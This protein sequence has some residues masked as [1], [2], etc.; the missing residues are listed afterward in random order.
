MAHR[1]VMASFAGPVVPP[2]MLARLEAG[3]GSVALF[4]SNVQSPSQVRSLTDAL[5]QA[6]SG[7]LVATDEEA[8]DVTRL[9][10]ATG[11][12]WPGNAA[13]GVVDDV[14]RTELVAAGVGAELAAA[15]IDLDLAPVVDVNSNPENPVIGVRSFGASAELVARQ[16]GAFV[17]GLQSAGVG[18]CAKHFPGHGDTSV[19]SH[20]GLPVVDASLEVL[21]GRELVPFAAIAAVAAGPVAVMTSHV[22]LPALDAGLPATLSAPV[23]DVLRSELG[24]DGVV[25]T[26]ALDMVGASAGRGVPAAAVAAL[27]AGCDLLCLGAEGVEPDV[28]AVVAAIVEAVRTGQLAEERLASAVG[29]VH[30]ARQRIDGLRAGAAAADPV[31]VLAVGRSAAPFD[32]AAAVPAGLTAGREVARAAV[33]VDGGLSGNDALPDLRGVPVIRFRTGVNVAV[34]QVPW[35]L[36][37]DGSVQG[38]RHAFDVTETTDVEEVMREAT[39]VSGGDGGPIVA[40]VRDAQRHPWV[41]EALRRLDEWSPHLVTVEMGWP[42]S[43]RL[44]GR[45]RIRTY[46]AARATGEALDE[47]LAGAGP[48]GPVASRAPVTPRPPAAP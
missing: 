39:S 14:R 19:D 21:Q 12:P 16:A 20:L 4:A 1:V 6:G 42:G 46:G 9:H 22:V 23:V 31:D 37:L 33:E 34:G 17:T 30:A 18:A 27:A 47:V 7:V 35:G 43:A 15:G 28:E 10:V 36:P 44:P 2:W 38:G 8:G 13:L 24:F 45:T 48:A 41:I 5:R 26:D 40:L 3:L 11:A 25:V 32:V 29:R